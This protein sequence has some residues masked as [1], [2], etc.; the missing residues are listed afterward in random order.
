MDYYSL[1]GV[2][3]EASTSEIKRAFRK[4]AFDHHPDATKNTGPESKEHFQ[5]IL[6]A[7]ETLRD[8]VKRTQYDALKHTHFEDPFGGAAS[9]SEATPYGPWS[10]R[11]GHNPTMDEWE[12][13]FEEWIK[14]MNNQYG[15]YAADT[16]KI[17]KERANA[18]RRNR[19]AA[20]EREKMEAFDV[21]NRSTRLRRRAET[22][23]YVRH[24]TI[25]RTFWQGRS[26]VTWQDAAVGAVFLFVGVGVAYHWKTRIL[27]DNAG[28]NDSKLTGSTT[29]NNS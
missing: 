13:Q 19:A 2:S 7:Y 21:K 20:W 10:A 6:Q 23:K 5:K 11:P 12:R 3:E 4:K 26:V 22:A 1:L 16:E 17:R 15:E 8:P 14:K 9:S 25:L 24:A 18:E 29:I 28:D 27:A